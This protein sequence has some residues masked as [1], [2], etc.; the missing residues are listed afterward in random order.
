MTRPPKDP[1][2]Q[3]LKQRLMNRCRERGENFNSLLTRYA[4]ERFL[5]RLTQTPHASRFTL[6]GAVLFAIWMGKPHRPTVDV[7]L[8]GAGDPSMDDLRRAFQ[9][10]CGA[11]VEPDGMRYDPASIR[12]QEIRED[13]VYQGMRIKLIGYLGSARVPV[14]VDVGLGDVITPG[15][16]EAT[17]GPILDLPPPRMAAYPPET[18]IAEKLEAMVVLGAANS[19]MKDFSDVYVLGRTM[20]FHGDTLVAA[21]RATFRRRRTPIPMEVPLALSHEFVSDAAKRAQWSAFAK[22]IDADRRPLNFAEVVEFIAKFAVPVLASAA[23]D[24]PFTKIWQPP[25]PWQRS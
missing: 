20:S 8:L 22:R 23:S 4:I 2:A 11:D 18:V 14:Q 19:R 7:D 5:Y 25:G 12:V 21:V 9:E 17:L 16:A 6:K 24:A 1:S 10:V 15:P 13:N 3:S